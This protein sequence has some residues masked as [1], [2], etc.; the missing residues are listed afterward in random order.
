MKKLILS[1]FTLFLFSITAYCQKGPIKNTNPKAPLDFKKTQINLNGDTSY[2]ITGSVFVK[3]G[4]DQKVKV[5]FEAAVFKNKWNELKTNLK[6]GDYD[7]FSLAAMILTTNAKYKL[8]YSSSFSPLEKQSFLLSKDNDAF[9]SNYKMI[10]KDKKG[11]L[12]E[13][14]QLIEY[15]AFEKIE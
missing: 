3:N 8:M 15:N 13:M 11:N 1:L 2:Y 12:T 10:G 9:I 6:F 4:L 5:L 14:T 7:L